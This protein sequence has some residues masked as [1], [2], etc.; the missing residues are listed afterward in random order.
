MA[1]PYPE[2]ADY[3]ARRNA[4]RCGFVAVLAVLANDMPA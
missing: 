2:T 1:G 3:G 4:E